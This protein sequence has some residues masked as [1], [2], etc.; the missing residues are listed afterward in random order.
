M[1]TTS[2]KQRIEGVST[3]IDRTDREILRALQKN[4]R[5]SNRALAD[6]VSIAPSTCVDRV[7]RLRERGVIRGFHA[8]V[9]PGTVGRPLQ[10]IVAVRMRLHSRDSIDVFYRHV[11]EL[12]QTI[13]VYHVGGADDYLVHVAVENTAALRNLVVDD[14]TARPEVEHVETRIV[15]EVARKLAIEPV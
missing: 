9:D 3:T 8:D 13:A 1:T 12:S 2:H 10:A 7:R 5:I 14:F 11:G 15:F 4:A 6:L